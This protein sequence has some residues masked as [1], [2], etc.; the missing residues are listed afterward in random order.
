MQ[1][2]EPRTYRGIAAKNLLLIL[3]TVKKFYNL[4][5]VLTANY[6]PSREMS[7][8]QPSLKVGIKKVSLLRDF[9]LTPG[10][11]AEKG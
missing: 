1:R 8:R 4:C 11:Q 2:T 10:H 3:D 6:V 9:S 7:P 5:Q